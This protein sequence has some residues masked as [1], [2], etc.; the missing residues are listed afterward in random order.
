MSVHGSKAPDTD[1]FVD[2]SDDIPPIVGGKLPITD[3]QELSDLVKRVKTSLKQLGKT[4]NGPNLE[5]IRVK[6]AEYRVVAG[7]IYTLQAEIMEN[8]TKTDCTIEVWEKPWLDFVRLDVE[9]GEEKRKYQWKSRADPDELPSTTTTAA[10]A[11]STSPT[12][13]TTTPSSDAA[14]TKGKNRHW[15]DI[16]FFNCTWIWN[17]KNDAERKLICKLHCD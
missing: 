1:V 17:A 11:S 5:F 16:S 7:F 12:T 13:T 3:E 10:A 2:D 15:I 14:A 8:K 6:S 4:E 9:C